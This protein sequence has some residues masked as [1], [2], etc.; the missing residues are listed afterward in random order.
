MNPKTMLPIAPPLLDFIACLSA[1]ILFMSPAWGWLTDHNAIL[2]STV[3]LI[4]I[5][6]GVARGAVVVRRW[7]ARRRQHARPRKL[8]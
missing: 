5:F 2:Q 8:K 4:T 1:L 3:Y 7:L 6:L